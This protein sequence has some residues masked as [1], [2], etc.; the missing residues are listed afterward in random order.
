MYVLDGDLEHV[1]FILEMFL[2]LD[3][4]AFTNIKIKNQAKF[5]TVYLKGTALFLNLF[6]VAIHWCN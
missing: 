3:F 1:N 6:E 4:W 2:Y 5:Y